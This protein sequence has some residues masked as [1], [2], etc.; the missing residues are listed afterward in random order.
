MRALL[1]VYDKTGIAA[2][3]QGLTDL[4]YEVVSTGGTLAALEAAGV[5]VTAV[6]D[7]TA[8]PEIL[9]GRVKTLHPRIHGGLLARRDDVAHMSALEAHQISPIDVVAANLYPFAE[10]VARPNVSLAHALEQIDIGGPAMIR[11]AAK[12]FPG[13]VVL[14]DPADYT[15]ALDDLRHGRFSTERRRALAAKAFAHTAAYDA[16]VAEYLR[17]PEEWPPEV[18]FAGRLTRTLRYGENPQQRAAAY[19]RLRAGEP[20]QGILEAGQLAGKELSFNNLLDADAAWNAVQGF[21][22]PAV[23]IVKHTIPC[24]L[25]ER[26]DLATAFDEALKGDPVSAFGGIV[27]LN[28]PVDGETARHVAEV[29]FEVVVAPGFDDETI[30]TLGK[31]KSL[32]LLRMPS[33]SAPDGT[34]ISWD[35]RPIAGGLLVQTADCVRPDP[36]SWRV[37]T[38]RQPNAQEMDDLAFA[39]HAVRHVKSNAIVLARDRALTGVGSGQPNRLESV[40]IAVDKAGE[41]AAGS[42]LAS[43]AFFPFPDGLET[44]I[45]AGVTA[46]IQPGGSVRDEAVIAAA[47]RTGVAM[48]FTGTRHFRH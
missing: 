3:G 48:L 24:G 34:G 16:V 40:R 38:A 19:R 29:F 15:S 30:E 35:V 8:F 25:S 5:P 13:V 43:D 2:L 33:T 17:D 45:A 11:A 4:G 28:R 23:A 42:V 26:D 27:A 1:S 47:D 36:S 31:R 18:T 32:R 9:D 14:T 6:S 10:T 39:W 7:V 21:T 12:N 20:V 46:A 37:V 44:A 41:R 22:Q